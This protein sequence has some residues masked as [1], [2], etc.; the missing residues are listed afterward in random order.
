[1]KIIDKKEF[2]AAAL[3]ADNETFLVH[4]AALAEPTTMPIHSSYQAQVAALTSEETGIPAEYSDFSDVLSLNSAAELLKHNRIN[5][6]PIDLLD[7]KQ[8]LYGPIYNLGPVELETLKTYIEANLADFITP[9]KSPSG[10]PILFVWKKDGSLRLCVDYRGLKNLT[11]KN[12]YLLLL[13]GELLDCLG[14]A[15]RFTQLDLTNAYHQ[16]RIRESDEWKT[17]FQTRY[18]YF[19]YQVMPFSLSNASASFQRYVK[20]I[21]AEKLDVFV[22]VYLDDIVIY[23]KDTGQGHIEGVR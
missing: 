3:N 20:K 9:S 19:E 22:I 18:G 2:A 23:I 4:I 7:D 1:M 16:M 17:A 8:P 12:C 15:N 5:D 21:S 13:I 14:H 10:A 6:H 11:I